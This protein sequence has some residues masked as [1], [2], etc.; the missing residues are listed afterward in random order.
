MTEAVER[1]RKEASRLS[2]DE[3]EAL[4][5]MLEH[6]LDDSSPE[7]DPAEVETAWDEEIK[8][9]VNEVESGKVKLLSQQE[10]D[11]A[12]AEARRKRASRQKSA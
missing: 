11:A 4:V 7:V 12:F 1:I 3:R 9:R 2:Y 5:R 10:F 8:S 6:D